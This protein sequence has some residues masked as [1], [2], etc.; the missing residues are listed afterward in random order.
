[1]IGV[2]T[3]GR[4]WAWVVLVRRGRRGRRT[5][6]SI[7]GVWA[8]GGKG[9]GGRRDGKDQDGGERLKTVGEEGKRNRGQ[10]VELGGEEMRELG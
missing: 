2:G 9:S 5:G 3:M 6:R 8:L 1:M 7:V 4:V 10:Q